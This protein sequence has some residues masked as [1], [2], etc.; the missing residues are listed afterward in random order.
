MRYAFA[1]SLIDLR[2][3]SPKSKS[4]KVSEKRSVD[5]RVHRAGRQFDREHELS[6][7]GC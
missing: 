1:L 3:F 5:E 4:Q 6:L 7:L 2:S